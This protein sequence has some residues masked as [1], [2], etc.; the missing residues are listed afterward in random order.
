MAPDH[1]TL[2]ATT[3]PRFQALHRE[4]GQL[5]HAVFPQARPIVSWGMPAWAVAV[6][7]PPAETAWRGTLPRTELTIGPT[8]KKSGV[9]M[10]FWHPNQPNILAEN[11]DWLTQAGFKVMVGCVQWNRKSD[12]P[13]A[14]FERL[15]RAASDAM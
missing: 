6:P 8:E 13:I 11:R 14:A 3:S 1:A 9:T 2:I 5:V 10:H 4:M 12:F 7:R 15:L